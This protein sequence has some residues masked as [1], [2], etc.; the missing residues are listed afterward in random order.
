MANIKK[1]PDH[2]KSEVLRIPITPAQHA[3][4]KELHGETGMAEWARGVL[5]AKL[6][7]EVADSEKQAKPRKAT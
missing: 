1:H 2:K 6:A 3:Q 4:I 5:L 7:A